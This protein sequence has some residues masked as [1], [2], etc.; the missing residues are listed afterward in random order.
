MVQ[1]TQPRERNQA[2]VGSRLW[3]HWPAI[4]R[5]LVQGIVDPVLMVVAD[6]ITDQAAK[7]LLIQRDDMIEDLAAATSDPSFR[8]SVLP[9]RLAARPFRRQ[10]GDL[11][12]GDYVGV[13]DRIAVQDG[14]P[15][16]SRFRKGLSQLLHH[17]VG[18]RVSRDVEVQ[19]PAA[20][21]LDYEEA[22]QDAA[23]RRRHREEVQGDDSLAVV[24]K[25]CKPAFAR[26]A[27]PARNTPQ[28]SGDG[29]FGDREAE[30]LEFAVDLRRT[31]VRILLCQAPDQCA[32]FLG[33][34]RPAAAQ[35]G[36]HTPIEA[37]T[38]AMPAN[39]GVRVH[40]DERFRPSGPE[41][42]QQYP[43]QPIW[44]T[45]PRSGPFPFEHRNLL[46]KR[47]QFEGDVRAAAEEDAGGGKESEDE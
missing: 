34:P 29:S 43:E 28:I 38:G 14:I 46:A 1:P 20:S 9:R 32:D 2:R 33:D 12:E 4:R 41:L 19:D 44:R 24:A 3:L 25:K 21:V 36:S 42:S 11:Q 10:S 45:Q 16:G 37:K 30:L 35:P 17:P 23:G 6:V 7:V 15:I 39:D 26:I 5:V 13:E 27:P 31:P 22:V 47:K 8:G 18:R 40:N